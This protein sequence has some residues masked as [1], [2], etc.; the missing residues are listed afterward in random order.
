MKEK[1]GERLRGE[2]IEVNRR[3][4]RRRE[5]YKDTEGEAEEGREINLGKKGDRTVVREIL[6]KREIEH[7]YPHL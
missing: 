6:R 2:E 1:E 4:E 3:K 5:R 7:S